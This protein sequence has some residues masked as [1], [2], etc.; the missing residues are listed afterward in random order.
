MTRVHPDVPTQPRD[1]NGTTPRDL[2]DAYLRSV[3]DILDQL[4]TDPRLGLSDADA[5]ARLRV[6]GSNELAIE[7]SVPGWRRLLAQFENSLVVLLLVGTVISII[8]WRYERATPL[9]YEAVAIFAVVLLNALMGYVQESRAEAA[10]TALRA[11][12]PKAALVIRDGEHRHV[13]A[14]RLVPGDV[15]VVEDGDIIPADSRL[16][17]ATA[18]MTVEAALTGESQPRAKDTG[19]IRAAL[20][21]GDRTNMLYAGTSIACGHGVAV[22]TATGLRSELGR[23]ATLLHTTTNEATP[24]Q[25]ELSRTGRRLA[26]AVVLVAAVIIA[27]IIGA[28]HVRGPAAIIDVLILGV[29]LAVSAVPE[30]LP[31]IVT[32]VLAVGVRRM[33][34]RNAVVRRLTAV[35]TLGCATVVASDKTGTLTKNEM[36]VRVVV[37]ASG[38]VAAATSGDPRNRSGG[39]LDL[40]PLQRAHRLEL[41]RILTIADRANNSVVDEA[42]ARMVHGDPTEG[43]LRIAARAAGVRS[44]VLDARLP[45]FGEVPFSSERKLMTTLHRDRERRDATVAFT[46]GAPDVVLSRCTQELVAETPRPLTA[47]RREVIEATIATLADQA[48]RV[49][50]FAWRDLAPEWNEETISSDAARLEHEMVFAGLIGLLDPPRHEAI[51]AIRRAKGAGIRTIMITGDHPRT[52]LVIARELGLDD[53]AGMLTGAELAVMT[54]GELQHSVEH[55]SVYARVDPEHKLRIVRALQHN[56]AIVAMTGDG[57]N[58][59]PALKAADIG[60]AMGM[61]GTDV[62]REAADIV[63]TD[64]N[65]ASIIAAIE[66]GRAIFANIRRFL[67]YLLSSNIGEVLAMFCGIVFATRLGLEPRRGELVLPLLATQILWINLVTDGPPALALGLEPLDATVMRRPPRGRNAPVINGRMWGGIVIAG[68]VEAIAALLVFD[69]ALPGG[70]IA[71]SGSIRYAQTMMFTTLVLASLV[72]AFSARF[73]RQSALHAPGGNRALWL[74]VALSVLLQLL[75]VESGPLQRA[76]GTVSLGAADWMWCAMAASLLLWVTEGAKLISRMRP[77]QRAR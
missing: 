5:E 20:P 31:A 68:L 2:P 52:A 18:L 23:I 74:A 24:L 16:I 19:A 40:Q 22:V 70:F 67:R 28:Q 44:S 58:D 51:D 12:T 75:V 53:D 30:G 15:L 27:T 47:A 36:T 76:F 54:D 64:D 55:V 3:E 48:L 13:A 65:F 33:A 35:E 59:A 43:A 45:R 37:T 62:A 60:V 26:V 14:A 6:C 71:G 42:D 73:G 17:V 8:G 34:R 39:I 21:V 10:I 56:G 1:R 77:S 7:R 25:R 9:P 66:E 11:A 32:T 63:L 72:S 29:A 41:E 50:G 4:S 57:V 69:A 38:R 61:T 46:K 49:L